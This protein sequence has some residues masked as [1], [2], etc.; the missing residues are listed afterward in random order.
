[1][2]DVLGGK[3]KYDKIRKTIVGIFKV[4]FSSGECI[5]EYVLV[6]K[7]KNEDPRARG[8]FILSCHYLEVLKPESPTY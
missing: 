5:L 1:V 2:L 4:I 3:K 7:E 6:W 8:Y